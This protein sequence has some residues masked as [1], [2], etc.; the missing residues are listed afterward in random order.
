MTR[1]IGWDTETHA[2]EPI[3]APRK[4]CLTWAEDDRSGIMLRDETWFRTMLA[5]PEVHLVGANVVFDLGV[6]AANF[7]ALLVPIFHALRDGRI[8]DVQI[9]EQ[10]IDIAKGQ[11]GYDPETGREFWYGLAALLK[12]YTGKDISATKHGADVWRLRYH[13]LDGVPLEN[14]P[15][16]AVNYAIGDAV[17]ALE[18]FRAQE[19]ALNLHDEA[20]QVR[21]AWALYLM[22]LWGLRT[23]PVAVAELRT[24]LEREHVA[25]MAKFSAPIQGIPGLPDGLGIYRK[26]GDP[27][28]KTKSKRPIPASQVGTRNTARLKELVTAAYNGDPPRTDSGKDV[29]TN[30]DTL[31]E[32]GIPYLREFAEAQENEKLFTSYLDTLISGTQA[33]IHTE[34]DVLGAETGRTSSRKPS[35]Q[36]WPRDPRVRACVV[37]RPGYVYIDCDYAS[38]ELANLAQTCLDLFGYS[39]LADAINAGL[40]LHVKFAAESLGITYEEL[41][42]RRKAGD[43]KAKG[44]RQLAKAQNYGGGGGMGAVKMVLS[45]RDQTGLRFC[46]EAGAT[47]PCGTHKTVSA[48]GDVFCTACVDVATKLKADWL[49]AWPELDQYFARISQLRTRMITRKGKDG[50]PYR[51]KVGDY[52]APFTGLIHG[53]RDYC[54]AANLHFQAPAA[55][56]AKLALWRVAWDC[57]VNSESP[58]Y[59]TRPVIFAHDQIIAESPE[60][61]AP[62]SADELSRIMVEEM[63]RVCRDVHVAAPPALTRRLMKDPPG[64]RNAAGVLQPVG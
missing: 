40:D 23:D 39:A 7:P 24:V 38:Q 56:G 44:A 15:Q 20:N 11:H 17:H 35:V 31:M 9:R 48:Q 59:G 55:A 28:P 45:A 13:E 51:V 63:R 25:M 47:E 5:D 29:S 27:N 12:R 18:I 10:L 41:D 54:Q 37:P 2:V 62:A 16:A 19:G 49:R 53:A 57:Y 58:L 36:V 46:V 61:K 14:W 64:V 30:Y 22:R 8:H 33:P 4:V 1:Y 50:Q 60:S 21:A 6:M 3:L 42:A 34:Y 26:A 32:S 43:P 52:E